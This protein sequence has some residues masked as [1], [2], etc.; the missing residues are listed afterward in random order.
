MP[1]GIQSPDP[2]LLIPLPADGE[3]WDPHLIHT[4]YFGFSV[5]D[6]ELGGFA[7][8]RGLA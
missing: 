6:A 2:D 4:H 7:Q 1:F 3:H 8:P 5:P